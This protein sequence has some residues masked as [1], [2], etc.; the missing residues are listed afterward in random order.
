MINQEKHVEDHHKEQIFFLKQAQQLIDDKRDPNNI[1][2]Y[3]NE[4]ENEECGDMNTIEPYLPP[5][6]RPKMTNNPIGASDNT[7]DSEMD[8]F[9]IYNT[10]VN[11]HRL[12]TLIENFD[13]IQ[14]FLRE[15]MYK[16][17][18]ALQERMYPTLEAYYNLL[19][20][21]I[22]EH[23]HVV[24]VYLNLEKRSYWMS[25]ELKQ[26]MLNNAALQSRPM[27]RNSDIYSTAM[28]I[29]RQKYNFTVRDW[30][31]Y[32]MLDDPGTSINSPKRITLQNLKEEDEFHLQNEIVKVDEVED[33]L[34]VNP[35]DF[36]DNED[37]FWDEFIQEKWKKLGKVK[38]YTKRPFLKH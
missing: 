28:R 25:L 38:I 19:P 31:E 20:K 35:I 22:R 36:Y 2:I 18:E 21:E 9:L 30:I 10:L 34:P 29:G 17:E 23:P 13:D 1:Q 12:G 8:Y 33:I 14:D 11:A 5:K 3:G 32:T 24:S 16:E 37:G 6:L 15:F 27:G 7:L 26:R 4:E